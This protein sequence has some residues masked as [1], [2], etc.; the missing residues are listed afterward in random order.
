MQCGPV[1]QLGGRSRL[2]VVLTLVLPGDGACLQ[3]T[4]VAKG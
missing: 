3:N 2:G 4:E 1:F